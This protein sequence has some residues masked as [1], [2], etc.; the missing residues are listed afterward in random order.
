VKFG[1]PC[2]ICGEKLRIVKKDKDA[3][4]RS[5]AKACR[6]GSMKSE[7]C[8][9]AEYYQKRIAEEERIA[10]EASSSEAAEMHAQMAMLYTAQFAALVRRR[11]NQAA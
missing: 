10:R 7:N 4:I 6:G 9:E 3:S 5:L 11:G 2:S 1:K 8:A